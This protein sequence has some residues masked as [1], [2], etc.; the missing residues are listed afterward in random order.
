MASQV[1]LSFPEDRTGGP[2]KGNCF[3]LLSI[4]SLLVG[5]DS[6]LEAPLL[7]DVHATLGSPALGLPGALT[8]YSPSESR[9]SYLVPGADPF[10]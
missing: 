4:A 7:L 8:I 2:R 1:R 10:P 9:A 6:T 5:K 3:S